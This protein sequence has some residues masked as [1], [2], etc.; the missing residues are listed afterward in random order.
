MGDDRFQALA[1][2]NYL[3]DDEKEVIIEMIYK[4]TTEDLY[5]HG[6]TFGESERG[7]DKMI[8]IIEEK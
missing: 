8:E 3:E 6:I 2:W 1:W 5:Q 7:G 4:M